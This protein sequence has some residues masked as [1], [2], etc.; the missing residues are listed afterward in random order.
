MA[1]LI[2]KKGSYLDF[3]EKVTTAQEGAFYITE[4]EGGL[5]LG[6]SDG[7]T[8]RIQGSVLVYEDID[9]IVEAV[10]KPPYDPNVIYFSAAQNALFRYDPTGGPEKT[11][12][13]IQLNQT[14]ENVNSALTSL[15]SSINT[16]QTNLNNYKTENDKAVAAKASQSALDA[17]VSRATAAE[18][19]ASDAAATAQ[20]AA[21]EAQKDATTALANA[22]ANTTSINGL[23][24]RLSTAETTLAG[25]TTMAEVEA[26]GYATV[27]QLNNAKS[28]LIGSSNDA[29]SKNT[30][31]AAKNAATEVANGLAAL[32]TT[33]DNVSTKATANES[34]IDAE[35][36]RAKAAEA[37]L[38][39][40]VGKKVDQTA[41]NSKI[42]TI[43][44][45][46]T[47]NAESIAAVSGVANK[48][49]SRESGGTMSGSII[50]STGTSI[51]INDAP[52]VDTDAANKAYV[53]KVAK[54]ANS[55]A[56]GLDARLTQAEADIVTNAQGVSDAKS[57]A[58]T[59]QSTA[60]TAK[61]NAA[62]AQSAAEKAQKSAD[63]AN[64]NA[65]SRVLQ[66]DYDADKAVLEAGISDNAEAI[67]GVSS[68]LNAY[69]T[70]NNAAVAQKLDASTAASTYATKT[71]LSAAEK[72]LLGTSSDA[73][74]ANTI[75]GAKKAAAEAL[76]AA[77]TADGKAVAAQTTADSA[78]TKAT[79]NETGLAGEIDRAKKAEAELTTA[80]NAKAAQT[81]LDAEITRAKA[82]EEKASDAA[83]AA[84]K[85]ADAALPLAGGTMTGAINMG[86]KKITNLATPT[87]STDAVTKAYADGLIAAADAM[88]FKGVL[89]VGVT[90][91][92]TSGVEC[93]WTYKVGVASTYGTISAKVGDLIIN[94]AADNATPVWE[95]ISSGYEDDYLQKMSANTVSDGIEVALDNGVGTKDTSF[96]L[97]NANNIVWS[98]SGSNVTAAIVWGTF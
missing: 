67:S 86:G 87:S 94:T 82:A 6:L 23:S 37:E 47:S 66:D 33:V 11:G 56:S 54:N 69:K 48:A 17:E 90:E 4:D 77:N 45:N 57:A 31:Y 80:V 10:G 98:K 68:D 61:T 89:G 30:I 55:V 21:E 25:K 65:N 18:K 76:S 16:V 24:T 44:S 15:Q 71:E 39:T 49:L 42:G 73:S 46:I 63:S 52:T 22:A 60:D 19:A 40:A 81:A 79:A 59:A 83:T 53:D 64:T 41:Y 13:W 9:A 97:A 35:V 58:A 93:G 91:L 95:H 38:E 36:T 84:Q 32:T 8:K 12:S 74:T 29:T 50:M 70:S 27:T 51:T 72:A 28:E 75:Y 20:S 96:V 34:A 78:L 88:V 26:K 43:E 85:T 5:Y 1:N 92:P 3:K 14:A 2:F 7:S 62:T